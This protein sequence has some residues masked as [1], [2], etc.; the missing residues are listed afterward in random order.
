MLILKPK[1][2]E[3]SGK[4][5]E[6]EPVVTGGKPVETGGKLVVAIFYK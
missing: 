3:T 5:V 6:T 4:P 2:S 1:T